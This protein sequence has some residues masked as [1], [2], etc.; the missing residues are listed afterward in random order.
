MLKEL[1]I[2][3]HYIPITNSGGL[4]LVYSRPD[5]IRAVNDGF[6]KPAERT[7]GRKKIVEEICTY[8][9]GQSTL[10][11]VKKLRQLLGG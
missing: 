3:E 9:D 6:E 8:N 1:Y 10:R 11:V 2:R 4:D 5:F 7:E